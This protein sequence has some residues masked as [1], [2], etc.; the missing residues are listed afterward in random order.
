MTNKKYIK[1]LLYSLFIAGISTSIDVSAQISFRTLSK[2]PPIMTYIQISE[3]AALKCTLLSLQYQTE[4]H[5]LR[6][7]KG[8]P[9]AKYQEAYSC[10]SKAKD[11]PKLSL[12]AAIKYLEGKPSS[13]RAIKELYLRWAASL[14]S[15]LPGS[16]EQDS[17]W[18]SR[19]RTS[20]QAV[21]TAKKSLDLE[22]ELG[23]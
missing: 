21:E 16:G 11:I 2:N 7:G 6:Y 10:I 8:D 14:D 3:E 5:L 17:D 1:P 15:L 12:I 20:E 19:K 9:N 4:M 18:N 13:A 23:V 22:L